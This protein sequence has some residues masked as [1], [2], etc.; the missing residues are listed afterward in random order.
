MSTSLSVRGAAVAAGAVLAVGATSLASGPTAQAAVPID[1]ISATPGGASGNSGSTQPAFSSDGR[2]AAFCSAASNLVPGDTNGK[3]DVFLRDMTTGKVRIVS[4]PFGTPVQANGDSCS[5]SGV[6]W[7]LG[8]SV[9]GRYVVFDST[10]SNLVGG[11][12]NALS[13]VFRWDRVTGRTQL[14]S[15]RRV[16]PARSGNNAS[17]APRVSGDGRFV[18]FQSSAND[19]SATNPGVTT[20]QVYLRDMATST[21][22]LVSLTSTGKVPNNFAERS[23]ISADA[24]FITFESDATNIVP[25]DTNATRDIFRRDLVTG[26]VVMVSRKSNGAISDGFSMNGAISGNGRFVVFESDGVLVPGDTNGFRDIYVRDLTAKT[27]TRASLTSTSAQIPGGSS[28]PKISADGSRVTFD[29]DAKY[30]IVPGDNNS[31]SDVFLRNLKLNATLRVSANGAA[32]GGTFGTISGNGRR[33]GFLSTAALAGTDANAT[34]DAYSFTFPRSGD[35]TPPRVVFN[36]NFAVVTDGSGIAQVLVNGLPRHL[37]AA[38]RVP[39]AAG[40][41]VQVWDGSALRT[42]LRR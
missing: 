4:H 25:G 39:V 29:S 2:W 42:S 9:D 36:G 14:V 40:Q 12:A 33:I 15:V 8:V 21:T 28:R 3:T 24:R 7:D 11:D 20:P 22:R 27:T 6:G 18:V 16:A 26:A 38:N 17:V 31:A 19:L 30:G 5:Q 37:D 10:A 1:L 41:L 34:D 32:S 23:D 13:D 35:V